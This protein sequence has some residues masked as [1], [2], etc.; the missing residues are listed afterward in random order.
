MQELNVA[1]IAFGGRGWRLS[2]ATN[3]PIMGRYYSRLGKEMFPAWE[4]RTPTLGIIMEHKGV[5]VS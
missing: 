5:F 2:K 3:A 1:K 4:C